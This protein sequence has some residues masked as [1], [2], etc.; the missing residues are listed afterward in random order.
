MGV[1][2]SGHMDPAKLFELWVPVEQ[3]PQALLLLDTDTQEIA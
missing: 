1:L 2:A 3:G